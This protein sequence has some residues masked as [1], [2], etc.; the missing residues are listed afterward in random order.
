MTTDPTTHPHGVCQC[1]DGCTACRGPAAFEVVR[2]RR[3]IRV[4]PRCVGATDVNA[5][6]LVRPTELAIF[7]AYDA[8]W[9]RLIRRALERAFTIN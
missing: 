5:V 7:E 3:A 1:N 6:L 4:C 2:N 9:G 8:T